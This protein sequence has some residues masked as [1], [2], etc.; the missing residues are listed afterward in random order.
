MLNCLGPPLIT[1]SEGKS[2][3]PPSS[4]PQARTEVHTPSLVLLM[5][6]FFRKVKDTVLEYGREI[7]LLTLHCR[8]CVVWGCSRTGN[9]HLPPTLISLVTKTKYG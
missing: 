8:T 3:D 2:T 5:E 7:G 1:I 4:S 9:G 6:I